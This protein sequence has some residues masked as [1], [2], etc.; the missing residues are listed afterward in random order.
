MPFIEV[1]E[2]R[3]I[4]LDELNRAKYKP[5]AIVRTST[6]SQEEGLKVQE[7]KMLE[8]M[9]RLGMLKPALVTVQNVTGAKEGRKQIKQILDFI[10]ATPEERRKFII[11]ARDVE[12]F[13]R[14]EREAF[15]LLHEF[16][17]LGVYLYIINNNLLLGGDGSEQGSNRFLFTVLEGAA[18][19]AKRSETQASKKGA[20]KAKSRG[21]FA[22]TPVDSYITLVRTSGKQ[23]GKSVYRRIYDS[24]GGLEAGTVTVKGLARDLSTSTRE[25]YPK[26]VRD[27]RDFLIDLK[28]KGGD[29]KVQEYLAVWDAVIAEEKKRG[30]GARVIY[31]PK[32]GKNQSGQKKERMSDR[33]RAIHRV[34][35]AYLKAPMEHPEPVKTGNPLTAIVESSERIG[36]IEDASKNPAA[37]LPKKR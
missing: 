10:K 15:N 35:V 26:R 16:A 1:D 20:R 6:S 33:A 37:Y 36:T 23:R 18:A 2:E 5:I 3:V 12:R 24:L 21:L 22:G 8:D 34:T 29:K 13:S 28:A 32:G 27:I 17:L 19:N 25:M 11:V 9:K 7:Q 31:K 30:V 4:T 14:N